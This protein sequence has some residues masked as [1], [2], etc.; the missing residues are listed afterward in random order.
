MKLIQVNIAATE[1]LLFTPLPQIHMNNVLLDNKI[2]EKEQVLTLEYINSESLSKIFF[3]IAENKPTIVSFSVYM[4]NYKAVAQLSES[5]KNKFGNKCWVVWGGPHVS[6]D[7]LLFMKKNS[8]ITDFLVTWYGERP[9]MDIAK[10]YIESSGDLKSAKEILIKKRSKGIYFSGEFQKNILLKKELEELFVKQKKQNNVNAEKE[11]D[12]YNQF[13]GNGF[14]LRA[15]DFIPLAELPEAYQ[16]DR[17]PKAVTDI[18]GQRIFNLESYRGCPFSCSYCL[19][20]VASKKCDYLSAD[21]MCREFENMVNFGARH[22]NLSDAGFGLKKQRDVT[23]LKHII[24]IQSQTKHTIN[25]TGYWFW[26]TLTDEMLEV[27]KEVIDRGI[28]GQIDV[29]IQTFNPE[30]TKVMKRPTDYEKFDDTVSRIQ[31]HKIPFQMDL[32][33]GL[34]GDNFKGYLDSVKNIM[35]LQPDKFQTFPLSVLPGSDYDRRRKEL[36]IVTMK[37]S[38]SMEIDS[39]IETASFP[40][41]EIQQALRVESYF[42]LTNP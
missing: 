17:L 4:W 37:G 42:Y 1:L 19:W 24:E 10:S 18:I 33:L 12:I 20:G 13:G 8:N 22:F 6:E 35:R 28:M 23:F 38:R 26:Q 25:L 32:I 16:Y 29:G 41:N 39:V 40:A 31:K 14:G 15:G 34:P 9:I 21:R 36:G 30:V 7:P 5:I 27:M 3:E 2:V 11:S